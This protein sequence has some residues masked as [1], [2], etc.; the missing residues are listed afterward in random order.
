MLCQSFRFLAATIIAWRHFTDLRERSRL[1]V[2]TLFLEQPRPQSGSVKS[3][4]PMLSSG[5]TCSTQLLEE[6]YDNLMD[7]YKDGKM[8]KED[9]IKTFHMAFPSR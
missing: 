5:L 7:K 3:Y 9:F 6:Y 2:M 4:I 8:E 1:K